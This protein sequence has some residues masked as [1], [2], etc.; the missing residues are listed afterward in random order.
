[1]VE[2]RDLAPSLI[3]FRLHTPEIA[4]RVKAGQFVV[5]RGDERAERIPLTVADY[6]P[7]AGL[8]TVIFQEVGASTRKLG[9]FKEGDVIL[10]VVGPLGQTSEIE[11]F[12]TVVCV[13]G[14]VGV[15]PVYPI[16]KALHKAG[17]KVISIIGARTKEL[18]ILEQEMDE[19]SDQI[20]VTTDDGSYGHH[21]FVTDVLKQLMD[22]DSVKI[23]RVVAVGP[24]IMM[25]AVSDLTKSQN[26]KTIVSLNSI[27]VD[28]T[29]MC[30]GCRAS[31]GSKTQFVCV[32][33]PEFDGHEVDFVELMNRQSIY[34]TEE[35]QANEH[36]ECKL[37]DEEEL[38]KRGKERISMPQQAPMERIKNFNEVALGYTL[39]MARREAARCL[40]CKKMPCVAGCP[41]NVDIPGF[42][43]EIKEGRI[44]DAIHTIKK[45]N[46]LPAIC[47]RVCPQ[48][49][50]CE[51]LCILAKKGQPI[52][53]G[54]LERFAADYEVS[55]GEITVPP[56]PAKTGK[57]VAIVGAGPAGLTVAGD[58]IQ[59]GHD[60]TIFEALHNSGGV[61]VYGIPEFRLPKGIVK[62]EVNYVRK[63]GVEIKTNQIVG[64]TVSVDELL[65][66]G[67]DALFIGT[68]AGLPYF[69][70][71][72]GENLNGVYSAN[73][74]L[75][76][77]NL[78]KSYLF[79]EYDTPIK[80]VR[81]AAVIGGGN[82]AMDAAR[83]A[84]RL[85]AENV[86]LVYRRSRKE[87]P[88][89]EE[90]IENAI[91]EGIDFRL[92]TNPVRVLGDKN[93]WV[94]GLECI[95]MEL[96]EPDSSGRRRPVPIEG[97]EHVL[98]V[99]VFVVA[100]GQGA[101]PLL[102]TR[103]PGLELNKWG[104]VVADEETGKTSRKGVFAGG[105]I[106]TGAATVI[107]AM[108]AGKKAATAIDKYL[109][110]GEW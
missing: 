40:Q 20:F 95:K 96:G 14:G 110:D 88:A 45:T 17:N 65:N 77:N 8:I 84:K 71:I 63:L 97:S 101:N 34:K 86:Y 61:L 64:Q 100:I 92:L 55:N 62:R 44:L 18:L 98:D 6:D 25:K 59:M 36:H 103:T 4:H 27:M 50:Q 58:L 42:I 108:G 69:M 51:Q 72:P 12:G 23:D 67:Y 11:N 66:N 28:G 87:M 43:N 49:E 99:E 13:G 80:R 48:E 57:K 74:F 1:M 19:I 33:G 53:I 76:R 29:G 109:R 105:D 81:N 16:A 82:V 75:T 10:D 94:K 79:P 106:V 93:G 107:L 5:L 21:G 26:L 104:N 90:E 83:V 102:T 47:G 60:V 78:M 30:G 68:G 9:M 15:A 56:A 91:E 3:L 41:V 54:R 35:Q 39:E 73:E 7:D 24:V 31:I 32:D 52:A 70:G 46:T 37:R 89:R 2:R 38:L 85:G 22:D